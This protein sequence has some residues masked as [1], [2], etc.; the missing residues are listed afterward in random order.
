M[1]ANTRKGTAP[2]ASKPVM[3]HPERRPTLGKM[4]SQGPGISYSAKMQT[5]GTQSV[6][7]KKTAPRPMGAACAKGPGSSKTGKY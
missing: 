7:P 2:A 3:T 5:R 4:K 1:K 6:S